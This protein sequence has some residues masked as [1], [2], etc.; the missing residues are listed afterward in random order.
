MNRG[1]WTSTAS[2]TVCSEH[3]EAADFYLTE[4][5]LRRLAIDSVPSINISVSIHMMLLLFR[6]N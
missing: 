1:N 4:S 2:S 5:G 3:F 6:K